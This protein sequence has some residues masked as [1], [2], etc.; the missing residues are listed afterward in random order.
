[1]TIKNQRVP[2]ITRSRHSI[3]VLLRE[4]G[5]TMADLADRVGKTRANC[6]HQ[7][8]Q[9][10]ADG[11]AA[12]DGGPGGWRLTARGAALLAALEGLPE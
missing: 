9:A 4:P 2:R 10:A 7:L 3:L 11:L 12:T 8:Q 6:H 1:M 5:M